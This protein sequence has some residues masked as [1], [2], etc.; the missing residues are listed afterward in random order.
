MFK[1]KPLKRQ[2][3]LQQ[4]KN[5]RNY[6]YR[7]IR[8]EETERPARHDPQAHEGRLGDFFRSAGFIAGFL[9]LLVFLVYATALGTDT[10]VRFERDQP[11]LRPI[12][13]YKDK[14]EELLGQSLNN[15]WKLSIDRSNLSDNLKQAFPELSTASVSTPPWSYQPII[16]LSVSEPSVLLISG[17]NRYLVDDSGVA[18]IGLNDVKP[19][20]KP[21]KLPEVTDET[22]YVV[23]EGGHI[24]SSEQVDFI[25]E[26]IYQ[27][28]QKK[29]TPEDIRLKPGGEE[30]YFQFKELDYKVKFSFEND[31]RKSAGAFLALRKHL[32]DKGPLPDEYIDAR[33][34]ERAYVR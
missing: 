10:E 4:G 25:K 28:N 3:H 32:Q 31:A 1:K 22:A 26:I 18:M 27:T 17:G 9:L 13:Q 19:G 24:L 34:P 30:V 33:V 14:A 15:R 29:L 7:S 21:E 8:D 5:R 11:T 20:Y 6:T 23:E 12:E 2:P 16:N